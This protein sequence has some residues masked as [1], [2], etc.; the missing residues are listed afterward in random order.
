MHLLK[1]DGHSPFISVS[2]I[3]KRKSLPVRGMNSSPKRFN[4]S[5]HFFSEIKG[6]GQI[7]AT[8]STSLRASSSFKINSASMVLPTPTLS[9]INILGSS[10]LM[11]FKTG[12][13]W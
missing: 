8:D 5:S 4:S 10:D 9:A 3:Q 6:L 2:S 7:I 11:N 13:Y 12:L 1:R